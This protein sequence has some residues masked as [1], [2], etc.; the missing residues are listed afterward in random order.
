VYIDGKKKSRSTRTTVKK[1]SAKKS[2]PKRVI[3]KKSVVKKAAP[4]KKSSPKRATTI[5]IAAPK[6]KFRLS[7]YSLA[8]SLG[9]LIALSVLAM[10]VLGKGQELLS[11]I[12]FSYSTSVQGVIV[13]MI[14]AAIWGLVAGFVLGWLYNKF[15]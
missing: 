2:A 11:S 8:Y 5:S 15:N 1:A 6:L 7:Q 12:L 4:A 14:E 3:A 13:G 9:I 10:S